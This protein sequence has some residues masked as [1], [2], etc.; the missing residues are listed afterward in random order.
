MAINPRVLAVGGSAVVGAYTSDITEN[1]LTGFLSTGIAAGVG[2]LLVL[3]KTDLKSQMNTSKGAKLN[4]DS[5]MSRAEKGE[6]LEES[7]VK[8]SFREKTSK[9]R[10]VVEKK[11][12]SSKAFTAED[13][14]AFNAYSTNMNSLKGLLRDQG[15]VLKNNFETNPREFVE[16]LLNISDDR[17]MKKVMPLL[18]D[19]VKETVN[20]TALGDTRI[21]DTRHVV[22]HAEDETAK[23]KKLSTI[24]QK[25]MGNSVEEA[26]RKAAM[27]VARSVGDIEIINGS[28]SFIDKADNKS[29]NLPLT[30]YDQNGIRYHNAGNG[31]A[32]SVKGFTPF[33]ELAVHNGSFI[34][35]GIAYSP[36]FDN[37]KAGMAP[38]M[39]LEFLDKNKPISSLLADIKSHISY[40]SDEVSAELFKKGFVATSPSFINDSSIVK[41]NKILNLNHDG[42]INANYPFKNV[43][44]TSSK[45]GVKSQ[46]S[47]IRGM[48][49]NH[50]KNASN[51]LMGVSNNSVTDIQSRAGSTLGLFTPRERNVTGSGL[52]DTTPVNE[53]YGTKAVHQLLQSRGNNIDYASAQVINKL[54]IVD[55][56]AFNA[57]AVDFLGD[58]SSIL[59]DGYGM[60]NQAHGAEFAVKKMKD[61]RIPISTNTII[62][63][64]D[65]A[66]AIKSGNVDAWLREKGPISIGNEVIA[67]TPS[68]EPVYLKRHFSEGLI[69]SAFINTKNELVLRAEGIFNPNM[70]EE[71]K[72][73][74]IG[75]KVLAKGIKKEQFQLLAT[76]GQLLNQNAITY[77]GKHI[78]NT[79]K[80]EGLSKFFN[81]KKSLTMDE[82]TSIASTQTFRDLFGKENISLLTSAE[83]DGT[84]KLFQ[85]LNMNPTQ[86]ASSS[87]VE[88]TGA[89]YGLQVKG[90]RPRDALIAGFLTLETK[91]SDDLLAHLSNNLLAPL[92]RARDDKATATDYARLA[93]YK[94]QGLIK[95]TI[96]RGTGKDLIDQAISRVTDAFRVTTDKHKFIG[97]NREKAMKRL[98]K[99]VSLSGI[100]EELIEGRSMAIG[101]TGM[102]GSIV[103]ANNAA[104]MSWNAYFNLRK[105]G[106]S[107]EQ[108]GKFGKVDEGLIYELQGVLNETKSSGTTINDMI[109]GKE[110]IAESILETSKPEDRLSAFR[111][112]FARGDFSE[113]YIKYRLNFTDSN[114]KELN[115]S[116][117]STA[118]SGKFSIEEREILKSL[119]KQRLNVMSL[120]QDYASATNSHGRKV[121][122]ERLSKALVEYENLNRSL[123][124]GDLIKNS[125]SLYSDSSSIKIANPIGGQA[126]EFI[127]SIERDANGKY[128]GIANY[129]FMSQSTVES[130]AK[131]VNIES[132]DIVYQ[133]VVQE[134]KTYNLK[135]AGYMDGNKFVPFNYLMTREPAQGDLS[136]HLLEVIMDPTL[137]SNK[138]SAIHL[139]EGQ[140]AYTVGMLGDF[141]QDTL[142]NL[143]SKLSNVEYESMKG[144]SDKV[145]EGHLPYLDVE[146]NMS[147][148][149]LE[150]KSKSLID[151]DTVEQYEQYQIDADT[152]GKVRKVYAPM[153]TTMA[154]NYTAAIDLAYGD[155][156]EKKTLGRMTAYRLVENLI[157]TAHVNTE[158]FGEGT[159]P[160]DELHLARQQF[161]KD[162]RESAYRGVMEKHLPTALGYGSLG[163]DSDE[164]KKLNSTIMDAT[165]LISDAEIM[166]S[167]TVEALPQHVLSID[168][169]ASLGTMHRQAEGVM[170]SL[171]MFDVEK[172][173]DIKRSPQ[174]LYRGV[175]DAIVDTMKNNKALLIGGAA[176]LVGV[177]LLGRSQPSFADSRENMKLHNSDMIRSPQREVEN[178]INTNTVKS[179]YI[180]PDNYSKS[181]SVNVQGDFVDNGYQTYNQ[182]NSMLETMSPESQAAGLNSAIF[183][184]NIRSTRLD[185][186]DF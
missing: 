43:Q 119:D 130:V 105:S 174:Q 121:A 140:Y 5:I 24:F 90:T 71:L 170:E 164:A 181:K 53:N 18:S 153:A 74:S 109:K 175:N 124:K 47:V 160:I 157:K 150:K 62:S 104:R 163:V 54:S 20:M 89:K 96:F 134:G 133:D 65:L 151:F 91:A 67:N 50:D 111:S 38:E 100:A 137:K 167:K 126:Q 13:K 39:M 184:G 108:L 147:P 9:I 59:A 171:D 142:Q 28:A 61:L 66:E 95:D 97:A 165:K 77:D 103:G 21:Q 139:V 180:Q 146:K 88:E 78:T 115:F 127:E 149:A 169:S 141:D 143:Y 32:Y 93:T 44:L 186:T 19:E 148:K 16:E 25:Q 31:N 41:A 27:I 37:V 110:R 162:G 68:G 155:D 118:R 94:E 69:K 144:I 40:N 87:F 76:A 4:T 106:F 22:S 92:L 58:N 120:D 154:M 185:I 125:I 6:S 145:R 168:G 29:I 79:G 48:F 131:S 57:F 45:P 63:N 64:P 26:N 42:T 122:K 117:L 30:S 101:T 75:S 166:R 35:D 183:G 102:G 3:P 33:S 51:L 23:V 161:L 156:I 8:S 116:L 135:R 80:I 36:T 12:G 1:P 158:T 86:I 56:K 15:V 10:N 182:F 49:V 83:H 72:F 107:R 55:Q 138:T 7:R 113:P 136:S 176:A 85:V 159:L 17:L 177:N 2:S 70:E 114:I 60:Y 172:G 14:T 132:K 52:R 99:A 129:G 123:M 112:E 73:H 173:L 82:F 128:K 84:E 11:L 81:G 179:A 152:K 46:Q 34:K 98:T 178:G